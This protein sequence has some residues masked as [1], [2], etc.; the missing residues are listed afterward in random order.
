M[1]DLFLMPIAFLLVLMN[2]FFVAAEFGMVKLRH[3]RVM[4]IKEIY[5]FRGRI[6]A[7]VHK[8]LDAYLSACQLGITLASLGLGWIGEPA[9]A[10]FLEPFL[11][12]LFSPEVIKSLSI[13][14]AF[15]IITFLHIVI[16]ELMPK[17]LAIRQSE[18]V[19][20]WTAIPLYGF[21]WL[22]YPV[23]WLLNSCS[24]FLLNLTGLSAVHHGD[25]SYTA[26]EIKFIL[27][28]SHAHDGLSRE[29]IEMLEHTLDFAELKVAEIMRP[30]EEMVML[31]IAHPIADIMKTVMEYKYSRFPIY[32]AEERDII[33]II[34]VKDLFS[35]LYHQGEISDLKPLIRP[36]LKMHTWLPVLDLMKKFR[37]GMP[38]FGLVYN[39]GDV[40]LGFVTL[41]NLLN[42]IIGRIKDEF[43]K[44]RENWTISPNGN[45]IVRGDCSLY[46]LEKALDCDIA[47]T[48]D[49]EDIE[50]IGGLIRYR[51]DRFPVQGERI[52]FP[53]LSLEIKKAENNKIQE[54]IIR[55]KK[56]PD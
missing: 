34:H 17:S 20:V 51:L 2:A 42:V 10:W 22:T 13:I 19:S 48:H 27:S 3:T 47:V 43:N 33:G 23:I 53:E 28:S 21:Y 30:H 52:E 24:N 8:N 18:P 32:S 12:A 31:N 15:L 56:V 36:V 16:G 38:H 55:R 49:E 37:E 25:N 9:F 44:T 1:T 45:L 50:T 6:L 7:N 41:D 14:L 40:L 26:K 54:L 46:S 4:E 5:G 39:H 35:T 11:K 29:E